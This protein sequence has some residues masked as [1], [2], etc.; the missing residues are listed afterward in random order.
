V[1]LKFS[2]GVLPIADLIGMLT[3]SEK[4]HHLAEPLS[5]SHMSPGVLKYVRFNLSKA[6]SDSV[7]FDR[8]AAR[9]PQ[10]AWQWMRGKNKKPKDYV[11]MIADMDDWKGI[12]RIRELTDDWLAC[13]TQAIDDCV[14]M[15]QQ[16]IVKPS[17]SV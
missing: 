13:E 4:A 5:K 8:E 3:N 9:K 11:D 1:N 10:S 15:L 6:L 17:H 2:D 7:Q 16:G 12:A 14:K